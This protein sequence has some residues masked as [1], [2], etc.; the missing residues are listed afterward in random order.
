MT[1]RGKMALGAA[2]MVGARFAIKSLGIISTL[3]LARLLLPAD[4]GL[5]ALATAL[6][7][8]LEL[9]KDL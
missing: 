1:L 7:A 4:F 8:G 9:I 5:V 3:I 6:V 2:W